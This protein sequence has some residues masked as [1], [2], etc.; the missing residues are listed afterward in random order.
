[1]SRPR[2]IVRAITYKW[3]NE[4]LIRHRHLSSRRLSFDVKLSSDTIER[5]VMSPRGGLNRRTYKFFTQKQR[6]KFIASSGFANLELSDFNRA[7]G[8][9]GTSGFYK[10]ELPGS[11]R[12]E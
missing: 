3:L 7:V 6:I 5:T 8:E 11:H 2:S 12:R 4:Y 9:C 1:M 10:P